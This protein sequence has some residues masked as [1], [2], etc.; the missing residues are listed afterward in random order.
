MELTD[1]EKEELGTIYR[2]I[3]MD[4]ELLIQAAARRGITIRKA[5]E[6][7]LLELKALGEEVTAK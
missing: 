3:L 4:P 5:Y 7:I 2:H 1:L 6:S